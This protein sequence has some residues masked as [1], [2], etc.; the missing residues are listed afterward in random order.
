MNKEEPNTRLAVREQLHK[1]KS[2]REAS[3]AGNHESKTNNTIINKP[4]MKTTKSNNKA[5]VAIELTKKADIARHLEHGGV[6]LLLCMYSFA[7]LNG[8]II[9]NAREMLKD[10]L[11]LGLMGISKK[12]GEMV[13]NEESTLWHWVDNDLYIDLYSVFYEDKMRET[14]EQRRRAGIASGEARR[15]QKDDDWS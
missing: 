15:K 4:I 2:E 10:D 8:G 11:T 12:Y 9:E 7:E 14:S 6:A 3:M 13:L 5:Y 1:D